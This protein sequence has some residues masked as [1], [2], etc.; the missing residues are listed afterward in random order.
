ML[1][2]VITAYNPDVVMGLQTA[3]NSGAK[4]TWQ[5]L[6][7]QI[8]H[9]DPATLR[10]LLQLRNDLKPIPLDQVEPVTNIIRRF[11]TAAMS[12]GA[13]SPEA[14]EALAEAM[15]SRITSYNVCY[16]KLLRILPPRG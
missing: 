2:E 12:L 1:Y 11:D 14:H 8:N 15:N 10:D 16:T 9:R 13:L 7:D 4:S 5:E 6:A 3:V